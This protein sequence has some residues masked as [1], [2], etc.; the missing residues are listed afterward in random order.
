MTTLTNSEG[1]V[2]TYT[3]ELLET[4]ASQLKPSNNY[5]TTGE[6]NIIFIKIGSNILLL[7]DL[8]HH[9]NRTI[10]QNYTI[11]AHIANIHNL[12]SIL[13]MELQTNTTYK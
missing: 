8:T 1:R 11:N 4:I 13:K 9:I 3:N 2:S 12:E 5:C 10:F 6:Q 7:L